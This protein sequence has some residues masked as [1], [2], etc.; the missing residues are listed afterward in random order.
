MGVEPIKFFFVRENLQRFSGAAHDV[1]R[2]VWFYL[3]TYLGQGAPWSFLLPFA[4][5]QLLRRQ[6][7]A[8]GRILVLWILLV[9]GLLTLSHGKVDYYLLPLYPAAA[10]MVGRYLQ[11][12]VWT[13]GE[14]LFVAISVGHCWCRFDPSSHTDDARSPGMASHTDSQCWAW[15]LPWLLQELRVLPRSSGCGLPRLFGLSYCLCGLASGVVERPS[16]CRH[17][18]PASRTTR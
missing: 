15:L 9:G 8:G 4:A 14:R 16:S 18:I 11:I 1:G 10:L 3:V 13:R 12:A 2:P 7:D 6:S 17:S 5:L